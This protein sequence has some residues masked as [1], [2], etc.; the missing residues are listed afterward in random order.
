VCLNINVVR[1]HQ[2][3]WLVDILQWLKALSYAKCV[4]I[5]PPAAVNGLVTS[6][7]AT[8]AHFTYTTWGEH[9]SATYATVGKV[10]FSNLTCFQE[11]FITSKDRRTS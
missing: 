3:G 5:G 11:P 8:V 10:E 7:F 1:M 4:S 2:V 6:G 9:Q